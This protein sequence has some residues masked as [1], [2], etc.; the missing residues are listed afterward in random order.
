M[1]G[2]CNALCQGFIRKVAEGLPQLEPE[3]PV[4]Y[5]LLQYNDGNSVGI[6][7]ED[8]SQEGR[9]PVLD[10]EAWDNIPHELKS[11]VGDLPNEELAHVGFMVNGQ[12]R[13]GDFNTVRIGSDLDKWSEMFPFF[14]I[15]ENLGKYTLRVEYNL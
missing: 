4:F 15:Y 7:T 1:T 6:L 13:L 12:R 14:D 5:G 9:Y 11:L 8:F 3:L 10:M 2:G